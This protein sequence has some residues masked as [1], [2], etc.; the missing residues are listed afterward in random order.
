M[1]ERSVR[2]VAMLSGVRAKD[3]RVEMAGAQ[4]GLRNALGKSAAVP[5]WW[6]LSDG[7]PA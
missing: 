3:A 7:M 2:V 5:V 1:R 4:G 6:R